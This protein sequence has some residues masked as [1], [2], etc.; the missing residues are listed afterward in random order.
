MLCKHAVAAHEER[1]EISLVT[2]CKIKGRLG[3]VSW[4]E[5]R[6]AKRC[7]NHSRY[8]PSRPSTL[9]KGCAYRGLLL[10]MAMANN[11]L[12]LIWEQIRDERSR[13]GGFVEVLSLSAGSALPI[14]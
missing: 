8:R 7:V 1:L 9:L 13:E 5:K 12:L 14:S 3:S 10:A 2:F 6:F 4:S 11:V